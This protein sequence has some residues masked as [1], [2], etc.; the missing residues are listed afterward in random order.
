L[1]KGLRKK[2]LLWFYAIFMILC[3]FPFHLSNQGI[4]NIPF[5]YPSVLRNFFHCFFPGKSFIYIHLIVFQNT[6]GIPFTLFILNS[7][8]KN[9][10]KQTNSSGFNSHWTQCHVFCTDFC[11][12]P[13]VFNKS[14]WAVKFVKANFII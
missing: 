6:H 12:C 1:Q 9:K 3:N 10:W 7:I 11:E 2:S 8:R 13:F 4:I 5:T 14:S